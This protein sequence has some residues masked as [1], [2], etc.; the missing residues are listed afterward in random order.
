MAGR[1]VLSTLHTSSPS[2]SIA[3]LTAMGVPEY[4][5]H[6]VLIGTLGQTLDHRRE[7]ALVPEVW[8]PMSG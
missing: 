7:R 3:R 2:T 6:D 1:L 5:V 4:S 8:L